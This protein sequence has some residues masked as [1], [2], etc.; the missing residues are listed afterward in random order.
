MSAL[1]RCRFGD[2]SEAHTSSGGL[3]TM[4]NSVSMTATQPV[5][6]RGASL[7][8]SA[9]AVCTQSDASARKQAG[10]QAAACMGRRRMVLAP[11]AAMGDVTL[12]ERGQLL[13][14]AATSLR[15]GVK[16][17]PTN[18]FEAQARHACPC[19]PTVWS[20]LLA[21]VFRRCHVV[22][23]AAPAP[24]GHTCAAPAPPKASSGQP[25][26]RRGSQLPS[27]CKL[28]PRHCQD[29]PRGPRLVTL[30]SPRPHK[31]QSALLLVASPHAR[32]STVPTK[33]V[34]GP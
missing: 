30:C 1:L 7:S 2:D 6:A 25:Q 11:A 26:R 5:T 32:P 12:A 10:R 18:T 4:V 3:C 34:C 24:T 29:H 15:K 28:T 19:C 31:Q 9:L 23:H 14:G 13:Q 8:S 16:Q 17:P 27:R 21:G 20:L 22:Q 33:R